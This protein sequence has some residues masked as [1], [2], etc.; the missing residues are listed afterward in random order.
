MYS[1]G[2]EPYKIPILVGTSPGDM[3]SLIPCTHRRI[4]HDSTEKS[5]HLALGSANVMPVYALFSEESIGKRVLYATGKN[6]LEGTAHSY[7]RFRYRCEKDKNYHYFGFLCLK[8]VIL[9]Q[10]NPSIGHFDDIHDILE[11]TVRWDDPI[12][13]L[14]VLNDAKSPRQDPSSATPLLATRSFS[15]SPSSHFQKET[16]KNEFY[17]ARDDVYEEALIKRDLTPEVAFILQ[18][19][20]PY[21]G[22]DFFK[23][24]FDQV[25]YMDMMGKRYWAFYFDDKAW[26]FKQWTFYFDT[27]AWKFKNI[28]L[29]TTRNTRY[30]VLASVFPTLD[31]Q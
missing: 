11:I 6:A 22:T 4:H 28:F 25:K 21:E 18:Y 12:C 17:L 24:H 7:R 2:Y 19:K 31:I 20:E 1:T 9:H 16:K 8:N 5:R 15:S 23:C 10:E 14:Q 13:T 30:S 29:E 26:K 3:E 27:K